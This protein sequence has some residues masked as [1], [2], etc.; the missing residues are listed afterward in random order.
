VTPTIA[1]R[2]RS[3]IEAGSR[4]MDFSRPAARAL[5]A[6]LALAA[7]ATLAAGIW[8]A[9]LD[10]R[11]VRV[12][13]SDLRRAY[14]ERAREKIQVATDAAAEERARLGSASSLKLRVVVNPNGGLMSAT[15]VESSGNRAVDDL[16]LRIV[17]ESA[18]FEP[19]PPLMRRYTTSVEIYGTFHFK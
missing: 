17:R 14:V 10:S 13:Y 12:S 18:P 11:T 19:F 1:Q 2:F 16:A 6:A 5:L 3:L 4:R 7:V 9:Y 8:F 15:V